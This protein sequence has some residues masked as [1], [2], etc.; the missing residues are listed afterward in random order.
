MLFTGLDTAPDVSIARF[1]ADTDAQ[2]EPTGA[3]LGVSVFGI[4]A[5]L[6][7][8]GQDV[9]LLAPARRL[10]LADGVP[11]ALGL[12]EYGVA[13]PVGQPADI[14]ARSIADFERL[15]ARRHGRRPVA[16]GLLIGQRDLRP[17]RGV[18]A[19]RRGEG[20]RGRGLPAVEPN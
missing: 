1:V 19:D 20:D 11:V 14:V 5:R 15:V 7:P 16:A 12:R 8:T 13:D 2:L 4:S 17:G 9:N 3:L 18:D 6:E 10:R